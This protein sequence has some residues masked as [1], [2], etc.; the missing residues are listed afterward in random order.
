MVGQKYP[1]LGV[2]GSAGLPTAELGREACPKQPSCPGPHEV[3][4]CHGSIP[5]AEGTEFIAVYC[6]AGCARS[7]P[8]FQPPPL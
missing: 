6:H 1:H 3:L 4:P 7:C 2:L 5:V 8:W